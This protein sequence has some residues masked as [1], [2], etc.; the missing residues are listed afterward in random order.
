MANG[1]FWKAM[2][3]PARVKRMMNLNLTV[4]SVS[5]LTLHHTVG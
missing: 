4:A 1:R 2:F 3:A 5:E